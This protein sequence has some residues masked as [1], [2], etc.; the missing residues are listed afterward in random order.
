MSELGY[1]QLKGKGLLVGEF[2]KT[3]L[4][5]IAG[6]NIRIKEMSNTA[7]EIA[8][9]MST[10]HFTKGLFHAVNNNG[11]LDYICFMDFNERLVK[12]LEYIFFPFALISIPLFLFGLFFLGLFFSIPST[13]GLIF[14]YILDNIKKP[15]FRQI[16]KALDFALNEIKH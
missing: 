6:T 4:K 12:K 10:S 3:F 11:D 8:L 5:E 9:K 2:T 1:S 7:N 13:L 16:P 15:E 14:L